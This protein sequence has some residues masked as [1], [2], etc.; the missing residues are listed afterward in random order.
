MPRGKPHVRIEL[1]SVSQRMRPQ[2]HVLPP[3][4]AC[5]RGLRQPSLRHSHDLRRIA[6]VS[7]AGVRMNRTLASIATAATLTLAACRSTG[8]DPGG[9]HGG[10][11]GAGG[12]S[13]GDGGTTDGPAPIS[14]SLDAAQCPIGY[15]CACGGAGPVGTCTCHRE[16]TSSSQCAA[17]GETC[18][19]TPSEPA[20]RIC[21]NDCFCSCQ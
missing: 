8:S 14:C 5:W 6:H 1:R 7:A 15:R 9:G 17:P 13:A 4:L 10:S 12:G 21:V 20:P 2:P 3:L 18:G 19:C 16:C 11:G